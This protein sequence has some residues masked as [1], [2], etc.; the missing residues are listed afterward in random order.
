MPVCRAMGEY[1]LPHHMLGQLRAGPNIHVLWDRRK[2]RSQR[3]RGADGGNARDPTA[4][5]E[6][7][8]ED[9]EEDVSASGRAAAAGPMAGADAEDHLEDNL[10]PPPGFSP[11]GE[12]RQAV[13]YS[14][15]KY[16]C[17]P[18]IQSP[19]QATHK[20]IESACKNKEMRPW[21]AALQC[22]QMQSCCGCQ[23]Q[24]DAGTASQ[25]LQTLPGC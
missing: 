17:S 24:H 9:D 14:R 2:E 25:R 7:A 10:E 13:Y 22:A 12:R 3:G 11:R 19:R 16:L 6:A 18:S 20:D 15:P 21:D 5:R 1:A 23:D 8:S 4:P